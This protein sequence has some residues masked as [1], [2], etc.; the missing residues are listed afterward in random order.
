MESSDQ[1]GDGLSS[2]I[3]NRQIH[4]LTSCSALLS[5]PLS[6]LTP[7]TLHNQSRNHPI[8]MKIEQLLLSASPLTAPS[9]LPRHLLRQV[10]I[11]VPVRRLLSRFSRRSSYRPISP[12]HLSLLLCLPSLLL[13]LCSSRRSSRYRRT[14]LASSICSSRSPR[15]P[16]PCVPFTAPLKAL[17]CLISLTTQAPNPLHPRRLYSLS[18]ASRVGVEETALAG[19]VEVGLLG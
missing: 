11:P 8:T 6:F 19:T 9:S 2:A 14:S 17:S 13:G 15:C 16:P 12:P 5:L 3:P 4:H 1:N 18:C 10:P 7:P